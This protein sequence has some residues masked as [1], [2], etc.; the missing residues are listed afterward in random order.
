MEIPDHLVCKIT[1]DLM[2]E[3]VMLTS[4]FTYEKEIIL[5]HFQVNGNNDPLTR[6]DVCPTNLVTN[7]NIKQ[8]TE[9]FMVKNPWA[10]E[11]LPGENIESIMM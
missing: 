7:K 10:F 4:G 6:E 5:K 8:A 11:W 9:D 1:D 3:P 2:T